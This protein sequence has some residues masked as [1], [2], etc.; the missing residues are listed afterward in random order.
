[1]PVRISKNRVALENIPLNL[2]SELD[3]ASATTTNIGAAL[4]NNL[5]IT[6]TTTIT[7][8]DNVTPGIWR[9]IR[10]DNA[11]TLTHNGTSLI[12][13]S[14]ANITTAAGDSA[15]AVS[16]GS[17]NWKVHF[18]QKSSGE[19]VVSPG[20]GF[21]NKIIGGDF[22]TNPWQR[23]TSIAVA[24]SGN[25]Y[26]ADRFKSYNNTDG[27]YSV[28]KTADAPTVTEA[29]V[30]T[31]HCLH[32]DVTTADATIA[33]GQ[34]C[35]GVIQ[36]IEGYNTAS[37]GFGQAG[38]RYVTLSFWVKSTKTGTFYVRFSNSASSRHYPAQYTVNVADTW[39]KKTITVPVDTTGT[40]LYDSGEGLTLIWS[41]AGNQVS[42]GT[43]NTWGSGDV[44]NDQV[45]A[46][47]SASNNFKLA[48]IQLEVGSAAT[49]FEA[50]SFGTE[51]ALCQRYYE[52]SSNIGTDVSTVEGFV[53]LASGAANFRW[54]VPLRV[55]KRS[56]PTVTTYNTSLPGSTT[57]LRNYTAVSNEAYSSI[58]AQES[59]YFLSHN[60]STSNHMY[61]WSWVADAE[62]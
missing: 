29:G 54:F 8:F 1:M 21:K 61:T 33:S 27:A 35:Q 20:G 43:A 50:R 53:G 2:A 52:K 38:T 26:V 15:L 32:I 62:L 60:A 10:F 34:V 17:G 24:A 22:T 37:L 12:L 42:T 25:L 36:K 5:K 28:I 18:Y 30:F 59:F 6:G 39:E 9:F 4:S 57:T 14:S 56:A 58:S 48:L 13:P 7:A 49:P 16:L 51:L 31:Q 55:R 11:L 23:G 41:L 44:P 47:D 40:W 19:S 45:N 3:I 46:L